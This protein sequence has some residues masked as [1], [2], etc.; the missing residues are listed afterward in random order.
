MSA[1]ANVNKWTI[2]KSCQPYLSGVR[3]IKSHLYRICCNL[4]CLQTQSLTLSRHQRKEKLLYNRKKP[5]AGPGLDERPK[6][7][8]LC[9]GR[10]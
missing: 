3:A 1:S 9:P 5:L 2:F 6:R 8:G 7:K 4:D 10:A